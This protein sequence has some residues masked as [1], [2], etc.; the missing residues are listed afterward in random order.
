[1]KT[2]IKALWA[3]ALSL[4]LITA[5]ASCGQKKEAPIS[6]V[7]VTVEAAGVYELV[8]E[9]DNNTEGCSNADSSAMKGDYLLETLP[10]CRL[11]AYGADHKVLATIDLTEEQA[12]T[13][14]KL[15]LTEQM[16]FVQ[17]EP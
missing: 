14:V 9:S 16:E 7:S 3:F 17:P 6:G 2:H 12:D 11:T 1:M 8:C 5:L 10:P 4:L 15:T 13:L